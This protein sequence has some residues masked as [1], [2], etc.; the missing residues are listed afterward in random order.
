[1]FVNDFEMRWD[2]LPRDLGAQIKSLTRGA[3]KQGAVTL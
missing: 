3:Q 1:M 2:P